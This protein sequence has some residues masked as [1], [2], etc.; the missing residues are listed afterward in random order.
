MKKIGY[1][2][3]GL[4][5]GMA[6]VEAVL[7]SE[8]AE[9]V[10]DVRAGIPRHADQVEIRTSGPDDRLGIGVNLRG[11]GD[12]EHRLDMGIILHGIGAHRLKAAL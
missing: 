8:R 12:V 7:E 9:L 2:V 1:A 6:H 5:I 11:V 4:G 3:L 10:A